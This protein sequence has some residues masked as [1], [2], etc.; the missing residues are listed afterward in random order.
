M[1][2][3]GVEGLVSVDH[4]AEHH[5]LQQDRKLNTSWK[6]PLLVLLYRPPS[7]SR[8]APRGAAGPTLPRPLDN[9]VLTL[10]VSVEPPRSF[11]CRSVGRWVQ[12]MNGVSKRCLSFGQLLKRKSMT[13]NFIPAYTPEQRDKTSVNFSDTVRSSLGGSWKTE[14]T[15]RRYKLTHV[16]CQDTFKFVMDISFHVEDKSQRNFSPRARRLQRLIRLHRLLLLLEAEVLDVNAKSIVETLPEAAGPSL[17]SVGLVVHSFVRSIYKLQDFSRVAGMVST[18]QNTDVKQA[19]QRV[20]ERLLEENP[21]ESLLFDVVLITSD[22]QQQ[23][24]SSRIISNTR[25]HGLEISRFCFSSEEDFTE[26]LL[27]NNVHLFLTTD[28]DEAA[29]ASQKG[30]FSALLNEK[31]ASSEQLRVV[32]CGDASFWAQLGEMRRRFGVLDSPLSLLLLTSRGGGESCGAALQTLR[33]RGL[34]MD[35]AY[36]LA[37]AP[38]SPILSLLRPH[39]LLINHL[40]D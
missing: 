31:V 32:F 11:S 9:C 40:E 27:K 12:M 3:D 30:V 36:C 10:L 20:N 2:K 17:F 19:L 14:E 25:H 4:R 33:S 28:R 16:A 5:R 35:E 6:A 22:S 13:K 7:S 23:Q 26:S 24:Q 21:S 1:V 15:I 37:G 18:I 39:F 8:L 29:Q 34:N 38:R